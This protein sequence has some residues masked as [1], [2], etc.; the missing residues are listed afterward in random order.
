MPTRN[1]RRRALS[2]TAAIRRNMERARLRA[3]PRPAVPPEP[4]WWR[5][6]SWRASWPVLVVAAAVLGVALLTGLIGGE[7]R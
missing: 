3:T 7:F 1:D 6:V 5:R 4:P 2:A